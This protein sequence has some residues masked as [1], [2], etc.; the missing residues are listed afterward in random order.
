MTTNEDIAR[1]SSSDRIAEALRRSLPHLPADA[2]AVV[3]SMLQP[4]TLVLIAGTLVVWVA[5]HA[6]GVGEVVDAI[7]LGVGAVT[8]GFA[9]FEGAAALKDFAVG[10]I[11]ARS[12]AD[13]EQAGQQFARAI[14]LLGISTIQA[15]L[16]RGQGRAVIG[17][18]RPQIYPRPSV[19]TPPPPGNQLRLSRP[20]SI[21]GGS[22][23]TTDAY[24]VISVTRNQTLT[25]QRITLLHELVHRFFSPRTGPLRR[26]RG[27]LSMSM[28]ARSA[29]LRHLEEALAEGYAQLR[30]NGLASALRA[31]RFPL[32]GGYVT[33][34]Q[35]AAEGRAIGTIVLGGDV[36]RVSISMGPIPDDP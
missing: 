33:I 15:L 5:S 6:F 12:D 28:Y 26:L 32:D 34:S 13:L 36:F 31:Y 35:L 10:A 18:G 27:E 22:L 19:G 24:G 16:L 8:L 11:R 25:E 23:G 29:L 20:A 3:D 9:V 14:V 7:L 2:R 17:R 1:M 30:V 4:Q 21:P